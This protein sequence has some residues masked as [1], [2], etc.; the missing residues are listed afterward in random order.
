VN[1]DSSIDPFWILY[2]V[3]VEQPVS[4]QEL[5]SEATKLLATMR[6]RTEPIDVRKCLDDLSKFELIIIRSDQRYSVTSLGLERLSQFKFGRIR[7]K[8]RLFVLKERFKKC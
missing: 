3:N 6:N 7:D 2:L 1:T 5:E 4:L 8:N